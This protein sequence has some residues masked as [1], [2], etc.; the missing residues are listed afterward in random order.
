MIL[1]C[2]LCDYQDPDEEAFV[3]CDICNYAICG[4]HINFVQH[5]YYE[6]SICDKCIGKKE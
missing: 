6:E 3:Y 1:K 4:G 2:N 5:Q